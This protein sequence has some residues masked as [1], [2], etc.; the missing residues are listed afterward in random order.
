VELVL[1]L[2][3]ER[4]F[5]ERLRSSIA[6]RT[7][8]RLAAAFGLIL[9]HADSRKSFA[10]IVWPRGG[11]EVHP[12]WKSRSSPSGDR[13]TFTTWREVCRAHFFAD[14]FLIIASAAG[15]SL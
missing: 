14:A 3:G 8:A 6:L 7:A 12:H 15:L 4:P 1:V 2:V 9:L 11:R 5:V 13:T 10:E